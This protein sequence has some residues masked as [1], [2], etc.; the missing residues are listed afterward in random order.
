MSLLDN[1]P[2]TCTARIRKRTRNSGDIGTRDGFEIVFSGRAC[3]RQP[4]GDSEINKFQQRQ[5]RV[6]NKLYF[7]TDPGIDER[8]ILD[9]TD[10]NGNTVVGYEV[11][12][13]ADPD[14]SAG[15]GIL[16]KVM[17]EDL[18]QRSDYP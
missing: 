11:R 13:K 15:L 9:I 4:A 10:E 17:I 1:L 16:Y 3:W 18:T 2:H 8:H 7:V 5:I 6:T 14:A 12:S